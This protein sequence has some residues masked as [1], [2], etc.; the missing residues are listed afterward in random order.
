MKIDGVFSGGG[1]KAYAF[2]GALKSIEKNTLQLERVAGTSAGAIVASFVAADYSTDEI[3]EM[4]GELDL[5]DFLDPPWLSKWIPFS[6]WFFLYF[7]LGIYKGDKL[8]HWLYQ[9]LAKKNI[10]TFH[11]L[12][13][14]YLKVIVS[15]LSL[16]KLV[17]I[18]DDLKRI[19]NIEPN[20]FP[21]SKAVR[22]S[23]GF[24]YF[25]M[26]K[27]LPGRSKKKSIIVDGGLLSN[28]PLWV[29][30]NKTKRND[31]PILG[32]KL[33]ETVEKQ[34]QPRKIKNAFDMFLALFSTM[35]Q[36]HDTRY[37]SKSY[38]NHIIFIPVEDIG[39]TDFQI[40]EETKEV[41]IETGMKAADQ[42]LK[43]WPK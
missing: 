35:K 28:F 4:L 20:Y 30:E 17:V 18:P 32:V 39:T 31:R 15:D 14:G 37:I 1:V 2:V 9:H 8:E 22:M 5:K 11:D 3:D 16:G 34:N 41:L 7:Q 21:V 27:K 38:N 33:S 19:Y 40:T 36:A 10:Y 29:F 43:G 26:P 23:A 25:F 24:P 12:Q 6:K 42:F 13:P